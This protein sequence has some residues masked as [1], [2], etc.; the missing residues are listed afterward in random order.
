MD[1][2]QQPLG[3]TVTDLDLPLTMRV[4]V[5]FMAHG[6]LDSRRGGVPPLVERRRDAASTC[7]AGPRICR[8]A[9]GPPDHIGNYR[10]QR[11]VGNWACARAEECLGKLD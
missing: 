4:M 7:F 5:L 1:I 11:R 8:V 9:N 3:V 10:Q 2:Q 6:Q